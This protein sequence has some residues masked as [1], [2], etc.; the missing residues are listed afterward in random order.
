[1]RV[2]SPGRTHTSARTMRPGSSG[3]VCPPRLLPF[4]CQLPCKG[5]ESAGDQRC[6]F[7]P[8][9]RMLS[10]C[11]PDCVRVNAHRASRPGAA[12]HERIK[13]GGRNQ[14][15]GASGSARSH[16][17]PHQHTA[18]I[19]LVPRGLR[20]VGMRPQCAVVWRRRRARARWWRPRP[21]PAAISGCVSAVCPRSAA[22]SP[23]PRSCGG[24]GVAIVGHAWAFAAR[25][26]HRRPD[27]HP[28]PQP[29]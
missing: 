7:R 6:W 27:G 17:S 25:G 24:S 9:S 16:R 3:P 14:R 29:F 23:M 15:G 26:Q 5:P 2:A 21:A 20:P 4:V 12:R 8:D 11:L 22:L 18:E 13:G 28:S 1:M 10:M 19:G